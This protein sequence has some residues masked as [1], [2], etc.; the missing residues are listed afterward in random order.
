MANTLFHYCSTDAFFAMIRSGSLWLSSLSQSN[1]FLEG[2]LVSASVARLAAKDKMDE[3]SVRKVQSLIETVESV[4]DALGFC[5]SAEGDLL[6]QWRG[7]A[8]DATGVSIGFSKSYLQ[9]LVKSSSTA[10]QTS[11]SLERVEYAVIEQDKLVQP[12]YSTFRDLVASGEIRQPSWHQVVRSDSLADIKQ[13]VS[14]LQARQVPLLKAQLELVPKLFLLKNPAFSEE[15]EWRLVNMLFK[16]HTKYEDFR[17]RGNQLIP[18]R[19]Y[20][21]EEFDG[22]SITDIVLGPK[23]RTPVPVIQDFLVKHGHKNV[24]VRLSEATYH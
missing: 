12:V 1:D 15:Q 21:L 19:A 5:L 20:K 6:S 3:Q 22:P 7:Y 16:P 2:K 4:V 23:H 10:P 14:D 13:F 9:E 18:Y 17:V 24:R 11:M 8:A